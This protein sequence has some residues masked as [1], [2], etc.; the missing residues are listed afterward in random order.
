MTINELREK[1]MSKDGVWVYALQEAREMFFPHMSEDKKNFPMKIYMNHDSVRVYW[2]WEDGLPC[3]EWYASEKA[4]FE[5]TENGI[6][7][8]TGARS[9]VEVARKYNKGITKA[10]YT[11]WFLKHLEISQEEYEEII[12]KNGK[13]NLPRIRTIGTLGSD[14]DDDDE[15]YYEEEQN[16]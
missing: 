6:R 16:G 14:E 2:V 9:L 3:L 4:F 11:E 12:I 15:D 1:A 7:F 5:E 13:K 8:T 10:E